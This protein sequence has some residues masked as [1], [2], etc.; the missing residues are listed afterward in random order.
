MVLSL[1]SIPPG[2]LHQVLACLDGVKAG[3]VYLCQVAGNT[4]IPCGLGS[5][6]MGYH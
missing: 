5:S 1:L 2:Y 4:V 3:R 6:E